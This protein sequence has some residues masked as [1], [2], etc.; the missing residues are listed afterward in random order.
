[1][2][3]VAAVLE[4]LARLPHDSEVLGLIPAINNYCFFVKTCLCLCFVRENLVK[5]ALNAV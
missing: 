5:K 2:K 1:M 3:A 4:W